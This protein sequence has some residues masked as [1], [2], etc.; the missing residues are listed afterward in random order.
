MDEKLYNYY[1]EQ[2]KNPVTRQTR[3]NS[4]SNILQINSALTKY[5]KGHQL[6]KTEKQIY[7]TISEMNQTS[8]QKVLKKI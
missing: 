1:Q 5:K 4:S 3:W 6:T 7:E 2:L 8:Q